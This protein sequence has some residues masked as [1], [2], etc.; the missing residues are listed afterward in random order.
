M[1]KENKKKLPKNLA[2]S[3]DSIQVVN[4]KNIINKVN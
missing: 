2:A 1:L 4:K 3:W